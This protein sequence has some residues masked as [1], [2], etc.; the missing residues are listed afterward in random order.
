MGTAHEAPQ[1][2]M[3][4]HCRDDRFRSFRAPQEDR[5][6]LVEPPWSEVPALATRNRQILRDNRYDCGGRTLGQL[7]EQARRDLLRAAIGWTCTYRNVPHYLSEERYWRQTDPLMF[8]AGHQPQLVHPGVWLKNFAL[9]RLAQLCGGIAI[10]LVIDSDTLKS[11]SVR[12]PGGSAAE[13]TVQSVTM[14][15]HS[16]ALP[17][18]ER[19]VADRECFVEFGRR[20]AETMRELIPQPLVNDYWPLVVQRLDETD[21]LGVCLAQG[22]HRLEADWGLSTLEVPQSAVCASEAFCWFAAHLLAE[23]PRF[24]SVHNEALGQYRRA[25][26]IRTG[27]YP[28]PD[29]AEDGDYLEAPLWIWTADDPRRRPLFCRRQHD[30][31]L[32]ADRK[33]WSVSLPL[34]ADG[35]VGPAAERLHELARQGVRLRS[36]ALLTTLWGRLALGELFIH[37]IGGAKYDQVT[38]LIIERFFGLP[39]PG[40]M[41][42]TA[43][44]L[45]PVDRPAVTPADLRKVS[46]Q[47]RQMQY[48][49]EK[50][51]DFAQSAVSSQDQPHGDGV[52][53]PVVTAQ[54]SAAEL[55]AAKRWWIALPQTRENARQR[56][57][58]IRQINELLQPHIC[59]QRKQLLATQAALLEK[60]HVCSVLGWR[61]YAF[62]LYPAET[63][64]E[65]YQGLLP[66]SL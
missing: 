25:H 17:Y 49:P 62:C 59:Q 37:G 35:D 11:T 15:R 51:I 38:D 21:K 40:I 46:Q 22:R 43:T 20:V 57:R 61:E 65:F 6:A 34:R 4:R 16:Q 23:L 48:H 27:A 29:L 53:P 14:D 13:P 2:S 36:R 44:V 52:L 30:G 1:H 26:R 55:T 39:A 47:L 50:Y 41:V 45:L 18:E 66:N 42:V 58:A 3:I 5:A 54:S 24:R 64:Q 60:L 10:N 8:L 63:L 56:C 9:G 12:V 31:L 28:V 32:L 19:R 33:G 7:S